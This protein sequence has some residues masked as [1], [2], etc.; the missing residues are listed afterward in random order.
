MIKRILICSWAIGLVLAFGCKPSPKPQLT[1]AK[2][3]SIALFDGQSFKGWEGNKD[4][5]RIEE[6]A[7][8]GGNLEEAIP[9]NQFLCTEASFEDFELRLKV[10]FWPKNNNG[11]IQIRSARIPDHHEVIGY[12]VD[13]GYAGTEAVW[14]SIYDESRRGRFVARAPAEAIARLLKEEDYNDY[15]IRCEGKRIQIWFN[16]EQVVDYT[17][18]EADIPQNGVICVQIHGGPPS[19]AWYKEIVLEQL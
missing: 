9:Q 12:Q 18:P 14:G 15:R 7:I 5:F 17:E 10:K 13:V 1:L 11:G 19:Q 16:G 8:V 3:E 6:E 2:G 4:F